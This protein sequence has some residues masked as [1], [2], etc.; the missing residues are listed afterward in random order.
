MKDSKFIERRAARRENTRPAC[1]FIYPEGRHPV[2]IL[3]GF[4]DDRRGHADG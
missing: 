3:A 2:V 4:C 1:A